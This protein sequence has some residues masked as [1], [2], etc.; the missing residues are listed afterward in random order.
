MT[1]PHSISGCG[2][3]GSPHERVSPSFEL[4]NG[5]VAVIGTEAPAE[6]DGELPPDVGRAEYER[7]VVVSRETLPRAEAD[8]PDA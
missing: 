1:W 8:I 6:L 7:I 4:G 5:D 2:D 3:A